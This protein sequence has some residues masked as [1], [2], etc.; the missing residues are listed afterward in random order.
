M[1]IDESK[2]ELHFKGKVYEI[3]EFKN[4]YTWDVDI[5]ELMNLS[6]STETFVENLL[7]QSHSSDAFGTYLFYDIEF[8][9]SEN[10]IILVFACRQPNKY[11][12]GKY[13]LSTL[14]VTLA[15][16]VKDSFEFNFDPESLEIEDDWKHLEISCEIE[17]E[18]LFSEVIEKYSSLLK[19]MIRKTELILS[20]AVWRKEYETDEKLFCT[21]I[22]FPLLRKMDFIDVRFSHGIRE[23]GKDFTFSEITKFGNLRHFAIQAKAGNLRGNVNA[24]IDEII[25]QL[26]DAFAMP[27]YEISANESRNI[28]TFIIVISGHFT[29]N[30]KEKIIHKIPQQFRGCV[31]LIDRDKILELIEKYWK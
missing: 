30:A 15:D 24:Q 3:D 26:N 23:Y 6:F 29:D 16:V 22:I 10:K 8:Y 9:K 28:S 19:E 20:G 27:Y 11:W 7:V 21:D 4:L 13:G 5:Q 25:G 17:G 2:S 1:K 18:F 14:L 31:Y 12:E